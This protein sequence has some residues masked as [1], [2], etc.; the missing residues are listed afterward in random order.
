MLAVLSIW[1]SKAEELY[2]KAKVIAHKWGL[3]IIEMATLFIICLQKENQREN[4]PSYTWKAYR[5]D[6]IMKIKKE[7]FRRMCCLCL[8]PKMKASDQFE[9]K[10]IPSYLWWRTSIKPAHQLSIMVL[11]PKSQ[12]IVRAQVILLNK[13]AKQTL[14]ELLASSLALFLTL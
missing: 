1:T 14:I 4:N 3:F 8:I 7:K 13:Q 10:N 2:I 9:K 12:N 11:K 6:K 5:D